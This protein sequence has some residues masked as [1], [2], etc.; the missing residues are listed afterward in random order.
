MLGSISSQTKFHIFNVL[1][2]G[3]NM[4]LLPRCYSIANDKVKSIT[5]FFSA[6]SI[7]VYLYPA[8]L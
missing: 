3:P 7:P 1:F 6:S 8:F 4:K 5:M 2:W